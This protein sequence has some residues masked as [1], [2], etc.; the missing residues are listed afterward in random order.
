MKFSLPR[1][2]DSFYQDDP[3]LEYGLYLSWSGVLD[4]LIMQVDETI[5]VKHIE[6]RDEKKDT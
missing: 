4:L 3:G 6:K 1:V 2:E 5:W